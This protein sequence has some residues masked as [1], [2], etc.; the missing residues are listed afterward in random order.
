[1]IG[2]RL[3]ISNKASTKYADIPLSYRSFIR[4]Y[5]EAAL[6]SEKIEEILENSVDDREAPYIRKNLEKR[7]SRSSTV[8]RHWCLTLGNGGLAAC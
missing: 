3:M 1:M 2:S 8:F 7:D 6:E 4:P 5:A